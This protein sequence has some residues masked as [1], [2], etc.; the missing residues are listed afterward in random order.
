MA[1]NK[2]NPSEK[3]LCTLTP[4]QKKLVDCVSGI[5]TPEYVQALRGV[6]GHT[7]MY[8]PVTEQ[9]QDWLVNV[10]ALISCLEAIQDEP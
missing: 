6:F 1:T 9:V 2:N 8:S 10:D 3:V 5:D 7:A 4:S